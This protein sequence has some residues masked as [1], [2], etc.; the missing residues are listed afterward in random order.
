MCSGGK[1]ID[2]LPV[3]VGGRFP[4]RRKVLGA[5]SL[6]GTFVRIKLSRRG[7][8]PRLRSALSGGDRRQTT[9]GAR[10]GPWAPLCR[11]YA[12]PGVEAGAPAA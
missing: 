7:P 10:R 5:R 6:L 9:A 8:L 4:D 1:R 2:S 11:V 3:D 12:A